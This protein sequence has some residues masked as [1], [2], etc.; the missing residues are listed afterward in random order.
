MTI[1][2][3]FFQGLQNMTPSAISQIIE[4]MGRVVFGVGLAVFLLPKGIEYSAGG[5]AFGATAGAVI[6]SSYLYSKYRKIKKSYGIKKVKSNPEVLNNILKI[7]IPI[8]LGTTVG[9][10]MNLIDSILVPQK[11]L[12]AGFTN[13]QSTVLYAQLTGKASVIVNVPL[14]LSMAICT[15][16]IP[17][18]AENFILKSKMN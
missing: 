11:L 6:G 18:I 12:Q 13:T 4:Q 1:F 16:L 14:T 3:G 9:S 5:A 15:S 17:I 10:I 8:S 2:R 7:A